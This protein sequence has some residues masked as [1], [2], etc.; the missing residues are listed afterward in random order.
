[1][2]RKELI[3]DIIAEIT[4]SNALPG[5][6]ND[7]EAERI[8]K[9]ATTFFYNNTRDAK[10]PVKLYIERGNFQAASFQ[11]QHRII[12]PDCIYAIDEVRD[13]NM[14]LSQSLV[15]GAIG[16]TGVIGAEMWLAPFLGNGLS[17]V[18][19]MYNFYDQANQFTKTSYFTNYNY[20]TKCLTFEG[21]VPHGDIVCHGF[22]VIPDHKLYDDPMFQRYVRALAKVE[23]SQL[24]SV[25]KS[26]PLPGG[27]KLDYSDI[28]ST[29][30]E[31]FKSVK[32]DIEANN[33]PSFIHMT[34]QH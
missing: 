5:K 28:K 8:I 22:K 10:E 4:F 27:I 3:L 15:K 24:L 23:N 34:A 6:I 20:N 16:L 21:S 25:V 11:T 30:D 31:E 1:M 2:T 33:I 18:A 14:P 32:E 9:K 7:Q 19:S 26:F 13:L 29:S 12:L 17:S